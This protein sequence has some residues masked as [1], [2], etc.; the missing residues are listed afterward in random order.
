MRSG[1]KTESSLVTDLP[2]PGLFR[3][4]VATDVTGWHSLPPDITYGLTF[5]GA[6]YEAGT[7][8]EGL[9]PHAGT[10]TL[11][12]WVSGPF[13]GQAA[14]TR[15]TAGQGTA[16]YWGWHPSHPQ[17]VAVVAALA[18]HASVARTASLLPDG[19]LRIA[20]GRHVLW[21]NF[22]DH[23]QTVDSERDVVIIPPRDLAIG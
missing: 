20:R 3:Q 22:T 12:A 16:A 11:A 6:R 13:A 9:A 8:A 1:F 15:V 7:W 4:L 18:D 5:D 21:F 17:A 14:L 2:L 10:E 23:A 19:V